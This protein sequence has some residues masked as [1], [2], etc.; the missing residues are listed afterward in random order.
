M[1]SKSLLLYCFIVFLNIFLF[2]PVIFYPIIVSPLHILILWLSF[3][4]LLKNKAFESKWNGILFSAIP[5]IGQ[6]LLTAIVFFEAATLPAGLFN[7]LNFLFFFLVII[8]CVIEFVILNRMY[9]ISQQRI[10][11]ESLSQNKKDIKPLEVMSG[12]G[13]DFTKR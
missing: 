1:R 8:F 4:W 13:E 2:L 3:D 5:I 11:K 12:K 7:L 9:F 10:F 6:L